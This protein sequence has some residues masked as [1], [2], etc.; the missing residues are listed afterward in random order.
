MSAIEHQ[1][2]I[3]RPDPGISI[4]LRNLID[5]A[6]RQ[7]NI[8]NACR[9]CEGLCAVFPALERRTLLDAGDISQLA[10]LCHDCR[11]CYDACMYTP[12]HEFDINVPRILSAVRAEDYSR[13]VWPARVPRILRGWP[14]LVAGALTCAAVVFII[15]VL[16]VGWAG[17]IRTPD[18]AESPY[19]LIPYPALMV[20]ILAATVYAIAVTAVAARRYWLEVAAASRHVSL[21]AFS[22]A[23]WYAATLRH[24]HGGGAECY[25]PEDDRPSGTRR[26]LHGLVA[27][28]F[29]L[30]V[31]STISAG[32]LQDIVGQQPPYPW[33]S[34]PVISGTAGGIG[35]VIGS[36]GLL[37]LKARSSPVTSLAEMTVKDYGLLIA[38]T[39]L[40]LS[41]LAT[42]LTRSTAAFGPVLLVHLSAVV[43]AIASAPYSKFVHVVFRFL[44][45]VRDNAEAAAR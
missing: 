11:A 5:E 29:G 12:P 21:A 4:P 3:P 35:L 20:L 41:G 23:V 14:G 7:L 10:N 24:L 31:V 40:A 27:F 34:A 45:I 8:C 1:D 43:L 9:Y 39:F 42:L 38:L 18:R 22:K 17:L 32:I 13:Y 25:Y 2:A 15:A 28:G 33:L 44:A 30:C 16:R 26:R 19:V 6:T 37:A 36:S